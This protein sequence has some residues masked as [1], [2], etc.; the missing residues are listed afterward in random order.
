LG[1]GGNLPFFFLA[2]LPS[3][4]FFLVV[5]EGEDMLGGLYGPGE[6]V[7]VSI[8]YRKN[9]RDCDSQT[10]SLMFFYSINFTCQWVTRLRKGILV[11]LSNGKDEAS[12]CTIEHGVVLDF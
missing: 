2:C 10:F 7:N 3:G 8:G 12:C 5:S 6:S 11:V 1:G 4:L 9:A